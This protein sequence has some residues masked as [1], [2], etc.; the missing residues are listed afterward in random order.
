VI[1]PP[2]GVTAEP[3]DATITYD[4]AVKVTRTD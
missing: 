3:A 4:I 2:A 1:E